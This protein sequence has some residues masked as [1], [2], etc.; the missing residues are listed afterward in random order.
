MPATDFAQLPDDAR[1]WVFAA[2][3]DLSPDES[4]ALLRRVDAFL[5]RWN[6]HGAPVVGGR[7][8]RHGRFLLV[9]ADERATGVSGCSTDSLFHTLADAEQ[10][11]GATLRNGASLVFYRDADGAVRGVPRPEFRRLAHSGEVGEETPVFDNT[12][13]TVGDVRAG[14][15]ERPF[16]DSWHA[17]SFPLG[18]GAAAD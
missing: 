7:D 6:A 9:A 18:V 1:V 8:W 4:A 15:W 11:L 5:P 12:I 3:R 16:R 17:R 13:A 2:S 10:E 14:R